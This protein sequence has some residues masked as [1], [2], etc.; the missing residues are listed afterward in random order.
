[1][2]EFAKELQKEAELRCLHVPHMHRHFRSEHY[3]DR[4][5]GV[6]PK[7]VW[8]GVEILKRLHKGSMS[9]SSYLGRLS[10]GTL[11]LIKRYRPLREGLQPDN[12]FRHQERMIQ[13]L[14]KIDDQRV[15]EVFE[16]F[17]LEDQSYIQIKPYL[18]GFSVWDWMEDHPKL[19]AR[20]L[21]L[22][23]LGEILELL[24]AHE[25]AH[26]DLKPAQLLLFKS[27]SWDTPPKMTLIDYDFSMVQVKLT[28]SV[29]SV[30]Y[31]APEQFMHGCVPSSHEEGR[32]SDV[33]AF[34]VMVYRML[35]ERFPFA[36]GETE[37]TNI[38]QH[39]LNWDLDRLH[40]S[41]WSLDQILHKGLDPDPKK[42]PELE[43]ILRAL[44]TEDVQRKIEEIHVVEPPAEPKDTRMR[45]RYER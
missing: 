30:P 17:L 1:M 5:E 40:L 3:L 9:S 38:D 27:N 26:M 44:Y 20:L 36:E 12:M 13:H 41:H 32:K 29:G 16:H 43:E 14:R 15:E 18:Q 21:L 22:R 19:M 23:E 6:E 2:P 39:K 11:R 4:W 33:Y 24:H 28:L 10:D 31:Y 35:L 8:G 45:K 42:R 34:C 25:I 37:P 7:Q